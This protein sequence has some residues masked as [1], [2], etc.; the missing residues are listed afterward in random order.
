M[1]NAF[2]SEVTALAA[3]DPRLVL[4]SGDIGNRLFDKFKQRASN[5]FFN[6]GVAEANMIGTA[7][8]LAL[9]GM[10]P[11]AYTITPFVTTRVLEQIRV[12]VCYHDVPVIIIGVGS[13]LSYASLG[14]T[15][16][17]CEDIAFLRALPG[18]SVLA[19]ADPPEVRACLRAALRHGKPTY[20]RIGKKGEPVV[21]ETA[22]ELRVG[23]SLTLRRGSEVCLIGVGTLVPMALEVAEL[24]A[25][26]GIAAEVVDLYSVKPL[27]HTMLERV[28]CAFPL[29]TTIEEHSLVGGAGAAI[30]EWLVDGPARHGRLLRIATPDRFF[31]LSGSQEHAREALGLTPK[32]IEGRLVAALA[33]VGA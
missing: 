23:G 24:L 20:I 7:A 26:R 14:P 6:C 32:A 9:S 31:K 8:G 25:R 29:V 5:R 30:A 13:G 2:A 1:R 27:D 18:M 12:D 11:V 15:H 17:A 28:F 16:H 4:L 10:R 3:E 33:T 22:P 21:H 19:P